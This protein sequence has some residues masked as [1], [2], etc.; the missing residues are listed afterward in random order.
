V[1]S[2]DGPVFALRRHCRLNGNGHV[3][4]AQVA[5]VSAHLVPCL[6]EHRAGGTEGPPR[7]GA[8]ATAADFASERVLLAPVRAAALAVTHR[9][10]VGLR[11][12]ELSGRVPV[13]GSAARDV[14]GQLGGRRGDVGRELG[15]DAWDV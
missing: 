13:L 8:R 4:L 2:T 12:W 7:R 10:A 15:R 6:A 3:A 5:P 1:H 9:R 11:G 14:G